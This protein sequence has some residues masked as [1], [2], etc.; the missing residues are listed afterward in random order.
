MSLHGCFASN[1][2]TNTK[3]IHKK[4]ITVKKTNLDALYWNFSDNIPYI[5]A[6]CGTKG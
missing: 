3:H 1:S 6:Y 2:F 5:L 4:L